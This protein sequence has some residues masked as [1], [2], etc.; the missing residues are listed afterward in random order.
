M[1]QT[2]LD[3]AIESAGGVRALVRQLGISHVSILQWRTSRVPAERVIAIE[4]VTGVSRV[5][6]RPDLHG[7]KL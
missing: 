7:R 5:L 2:A 1:R 4:T 3:R 6:L